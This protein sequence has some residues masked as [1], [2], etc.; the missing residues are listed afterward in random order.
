MAHTE[1]SKENRLAHAILD[2]FVLQN[3]IR[4]RM[5]YVKV[6]CDMLSRLRKIAQS[7]FGYNLKAASS[8]FS[9][10]LTI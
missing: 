8:S 6:C 9:V 1:N 7:S 3:F 10:D 2:A 4:L 5:L